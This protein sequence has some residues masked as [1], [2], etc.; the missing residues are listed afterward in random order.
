MNMQDIIK[1]Y[2]P[3]LT[4]KNASTPPSAWYTEPGIAVL[5]NEQVFA[6]NWLIAARVEQLAEPGPEFPD[7]WKLPPICRWR[8]GR[9]HPARARGRAGAAT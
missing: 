4:L 2:Q 1:R 5:E 3:D 7:G 8:A 6:N 9:R